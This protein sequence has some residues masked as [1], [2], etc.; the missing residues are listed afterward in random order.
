MAKA[1]LFHVL[2]IPVFAF[3]L[4]WALPAEGWRHLWKRLPL[5]FL[6][7]VLFSFLNLLH[8][9]GHIVDAVIFSGYRKITVRAPVFIL[10]IPRSGTTYLH[11]LLGANSDFTTFSTWEAL[12]AP[13]VSE[14]YLFT[15]LGKLLKPLEKGALWI[16]GKFFQQMDTIHKLGL[17]E[18]E[19]DFLLLLPVLACL[20]PV[21]AC[22]GSSHYWRLAN[23][24]KKAR[25]SYR[26]MVLAFYRCCLQKHLY[27]H[28]SEKRL[29]SKNPS[30]TSW[31]SSLLATF[32]G[33]RLVA[34]VRAPQEVVP[35]Q[36]SSLRPIMSLLGDNKL[37]SLTQEKMIG[38]L[39][40]YYRILAASTQEPG[41]HF[42]PMPL[43]QAN[44]PKTMTA[45]A[46]FLS[47]P[48]SSSIAPDCL[49]KK[50]RSS[51]KYSSKHKYSLD[52]F[53]IDPAELDAL[54]NA[55]WPLAVNRQSE[56]TI[57]QGNGIN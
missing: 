13:S 23:F 46:Y 15:F 51:K 48:D 4:I 14:K 18:P 55:C 20:L 31:T 40:N 12:L 11:R 6:F 49:L 7:W 19:E 47:D 1:L 22:P 2:A 36:L 42:L 33:A 57:D 53:G 32:P 50:E 24:D 9:V 54:F 16:R 29:L 27:F 10:G 38:L 30:F 21:F 25:A 17:Q 39:L 28:G 44:D 8:L 26:A 45:L 35:S 52:E 34:C 3:Q 43:L 41:M 56:R 5:F 37:S